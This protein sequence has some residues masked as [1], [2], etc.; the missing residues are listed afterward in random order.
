MT[1]AVAWRGVVLLVSQHLHEVKADG[2][3]NEAVQQVAFADR[4]L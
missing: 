2:S 4:I 1:V 3:V